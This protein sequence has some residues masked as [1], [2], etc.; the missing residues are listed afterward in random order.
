MKRC[1]VCNRSYSDD[2]FSFCLADGSLLSASYDSDVTLVF[3]SART[4]D[5]SPTL[6]I[7]EPVI[8][9]NINKQY[10]HVKSAEDLYH[11]TRGIWRLSRQRAERAKYAFAVYQGVIK[12]VYEIDRWIPA[13]NET[14]EYWHKREKTQGK[15]FPP[16]VHDGRSEFIGKLA[17]EVIRKKYVGQRMPVRHS[18]NPIRYINC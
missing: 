11:C 6:R 17:P 16:E 12:E 4:S 7:D 1:P 9:I 15:Y 8:A 14:R 13:S 18:Q 10:P 5:P 3:P 2:T